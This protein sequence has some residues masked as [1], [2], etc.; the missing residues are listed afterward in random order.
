M[1]MVSWAPIISQN[2]WATSLV[3][4]K[5]SNVTVPITVSAVIFDSGT[6]LIYMPSQEYNIIRKEIVRDKRCYLD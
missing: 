2:Y 1:K 6:S 4:A 3:S 5:V